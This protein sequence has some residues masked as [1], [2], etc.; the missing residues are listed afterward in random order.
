M[1]DIEYYKL[2]NGEKPVKN[3]LDSLDTK[4]RVKALGSIDILAKFGNNLR[5]K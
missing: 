4:M 3:F 1:F 2:P 5:E